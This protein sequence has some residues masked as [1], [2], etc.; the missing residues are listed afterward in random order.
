MLFRLLVML[1]LCAC[2]TPLIAQQA[3]GAGSIDNALT[4]KYIDAVAGKSE[5]L[6]A[7]L[8]KQTKRYLNKLQKQE[9]KL[10][11]KLYKID[12]LA[13][14]NLFTESA[15]KYESFKQ[16]AN[17]KVGK[18]IPL[19]DTFTTS[20]KFLDKYKSTFSGI[21]QSS[22]QLKEALSKTK[23]LEDKFR[24]CDDIRAFIKER[25]DLLRQQLQ[26]YNLGSKL[27]QFNQDAY[28]YSQQVQEYKDAL[29]DPDRIERKAIELL[30]KV[31]AFKEFM[32]K[33]SLLAS[34]FPKPEN[35]G[36]AAALAGL[37]TRE[38]V[39]QLLEEKIAAGGPN[40][41]EVLQQNLNASHNA[42]DNLKKKA[43]ELGRSKDNDLD[44]PDF[45]L[46]PQKT[47]S[48]LQRLE[49]GTNIQTQK[50]GLFF[51]TTTDL[52][53]SVGYKLTDKSI[54]GIGASYKMGWGKD[55]KHISITHEGIGFRS[56]AD[57][58]IKGSFYAS[59]GF[60]YNYQQPFNSLQQINNLNNWQQSGLVGVS[61]VVSLKTKFFK[62]TKLQ[63]LWDFLS[64]QQRPVTQPIKFR[65]GYSFN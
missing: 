7:Q 49:Y 35:Y 27:K 37:Q 51:P 42:F 36:T 23:D 5:K 26:K 38:Q 43:S 45:K 32:E 21:K 56:F 1:L 12:S 41:K 58:R 61:K 57:V 14:N 24:Q 40:A 10:Q 64:Y 9:A 54:I 65:V 29:Q 47:K 6:S 50:S 11:K 34:M 62:K 33:N 55:I 52:A 3:P 19:L 25:S 15:K 44:M 31:P 28:Y 2:G 39:Q 16:K 48:F 17:A 59:G 30:T 63:L 4:S 20:L 18:Y 8:D 60:E 22:A 53:L 46:N 13:A